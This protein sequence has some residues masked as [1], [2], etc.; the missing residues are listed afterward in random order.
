LPLAEAA[1]QSLSQEVPSTRTKNSRG[2][3]T[4]TPPWCATTD[5]AAH[6]RLPEQNCTDMRGSHTLRDTSFQLFAKLAYQSPQAP[7]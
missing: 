2:V 1:M 6:T 7:R 4:P 3:G 5:T